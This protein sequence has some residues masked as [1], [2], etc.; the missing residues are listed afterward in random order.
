MKRIIFTF[1]F[2][3][4]Y[5]ILSRNF[6]RQYIGD[7]TWLFKNYNLS[8]ICYGLDELMVLNISN[9][10]DYDKNFLKIIEQI[11]ETCFL[12]LTVGGKINSLNDADKY[13]KVGA[14]K[15]F[16]NDLIFKNSN[17]CNELA[18]TYGSQAVMGGINVSFIKN[19]Y[20]VFKSDGLTKYNKNFNYHLNYLLDINIGEVLIQSIDND[21]TGVG[22]DL[23]ILDLIPKN[24]PLPIILMGGIGKKQHIIDGLSNTKVDA[25]ST[26]NILN[27]IGSSLLTVRHDAINAGINI[28]QL[29]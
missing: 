22:L 5:F 23:S 18:K 3:N 6:R 4:D 16:V 15:I 25:I 11:S 26:A 1:L 10:P 2:F 14:D 24:F 12:P 27:F 29:K 21:G 28:P 20:F 7:H 19:N 13:F 8:K 9:S 17:I